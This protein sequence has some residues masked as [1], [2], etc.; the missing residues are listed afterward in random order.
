MNIYSI[1]DIEELYLKGIEAYT[2]DEF[3]LAVKY[4]QKCLDIKP[5]YSKAQKNIAK[6]QKK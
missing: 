6:A 2:N 4:W 5:D 1:E 3:R